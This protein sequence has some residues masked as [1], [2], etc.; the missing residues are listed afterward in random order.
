MIFLPDTTYRTGE[1]LVR[2]T[3]SSTDTLSTTTTVAEKLFRVQGMLQSREGAQSSTRT[4]ESKREDISSKTVTKA[5][6]SRR[7]TS[8]KWMNPMSHG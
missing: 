6:T 1:R 3:D 2:L 4:I 7:T 5:T 8:N